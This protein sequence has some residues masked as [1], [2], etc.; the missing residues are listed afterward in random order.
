MND[1]QNAFE[2]VLS[3]VDKANCGRHL[4]LIGSWAEFVY[5]E[6]GV[7]P[8]FD[9]RIKTLDIDFLVKNLRRPMPPAS[10]ASLA[11][12][13]GFLVEADR[14]NQTTKLYDPSGLEVEF[15]I[16]KMGAGIEPS[17]KT[18]IG[19]TAQALRHLEI[20]SRD[21]LQVICLGHL[22]T[23]PIPEAYTA[24][25]MVINNDR[26]AKKDKDAEAVK[27][28]WSHLDE[29]VFDTVVSKLTKKEKAAV[30]TFLTEHELR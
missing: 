30:S 4:V 3:L 28:L 14:L 17:L 2:R 19:V 11:R 1:Q 23:V 6:A 29:G 12:E 24:H 27:W 15:L 22:I 13:E 9:P 5:R 20:L 21:T 25:K 16:N 7:L 8:N 18:N 10:L 26:K